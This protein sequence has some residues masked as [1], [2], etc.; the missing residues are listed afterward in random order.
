MTKIET[1][2]RTLLCEWAKPNRDLGI[3]EKQLPVIEM[4]LSNLEA[5]SKLSHDSVNVIHSTFKILV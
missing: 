4:E 3:I 5:L 1:L 2:H